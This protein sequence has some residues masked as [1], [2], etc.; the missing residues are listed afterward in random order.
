MSWA[1]PALGPT[2]DVIRH[3]GPSGT[4][5]GST[6]QGQPGRAITHDD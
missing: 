4:V 1:R 5:S 3:D 6:V 2:T